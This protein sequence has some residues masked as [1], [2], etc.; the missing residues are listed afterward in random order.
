M[1]PAVDLEWGPAVLTATTGLRHAIVHQPSADTAL[2]WIRPGVIDEPI[3]APVAAHHH[4]IL[5]GAST[6]RARFVTP[7][8]YGDGLL[9]RTAAPLTAAFWHDAGPMVHDR[10][11]AALTEVVHGLTGLHRHRVADPLA[12]A[13]G[14]IRLLRWLDGPHRAGHG[15][16][17]HSLAREIWG[18][19]GLDRIRAWARESCGGPG[20]LLHGNVSLAS[21]LPSVS[22]DPLPVEILSGAE[23][24]S[25]DPAF[26]LGWLLGE[27][28]ELAFVA[29]GLDRSRAPDLRTDPLAGPILRAAADLDPELVHRAVVLRI[30]THMRDHAAAMPWD[31]EL[32]KYT[33]LIGTLLAVAPGYPGTH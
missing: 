23:L 4:R 16:R 5:A 20:V 17:L 19:A 10:L 24:T 3:G 32:H 6:A 26:D 27:L 22:G 1:T 30:V 11:A 7:E 8:P 28:T 18:V 13:P 2:W 25:G 33:H 9:Y 31:N 12:P 15:D 14:I 29:G 21:I